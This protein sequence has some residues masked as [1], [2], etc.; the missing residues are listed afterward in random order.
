MMNSTFL[1]MPKLNFLDLEKSF[2]RGQNVMSPPIL[3]DNILPT[4]DSVSLWSKS[5]KR[6]RFFYLKN[7]NL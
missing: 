3:R 1:L 5:E 4:Y 2:L 7:I 6:T